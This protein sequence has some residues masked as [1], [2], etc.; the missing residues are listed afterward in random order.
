MKRSKSRIKFLTCL[1]LLVV[2]VPV[3]LN[4]FYNSQLKPVT[5]QE[6]VKRFVIT[7]GQPFS[8]IT[9]NLQ[10]EKLIK[11]ALAFRLLAAQ[12]GITNKIQAGDYSLPTNL[13]AQ[14]MAQF[15]THGALDIWITFPEGQRIEQQAKVIEER[16]NTQ[17]NNQYQFD[18]GEYIA[19]ADE[20]YMFP[21]TYLI[22]KEA[23]ASAVVEKLR[24]TFESKV[25]KSLLLSGIK[26]GL[27]ELEVITLAS[28]IEREAKTNEERPVIAGILL[29]RSNEGMPLQVDATVQYAKGY[30]AGNATWWPQVTIEDYKAVNSPYNTYLHTGLPPGPISNPGLES[31]RAAAEPVDTPYFFYLHD[32]KGKIHYAKTGEQHNANIQKYL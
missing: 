3:L 27:T 20:G 12:L 21:D 25:P 13:S 2:A 31:I 1:V 29:N 32:S 14:E 26:N 6:S 9:A 17:N 11:S 4:L 30:D 23:S 8:Q 22:S 28:I 15:L 18:K 24:S 5:S 16:L 7:P 10:K 19:L